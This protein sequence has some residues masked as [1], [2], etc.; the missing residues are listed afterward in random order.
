[1]RKKK[2]QPYDFSPMDFSLK[3]RAMAENRSFSTIALLCDL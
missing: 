1:M 3:R 2:G